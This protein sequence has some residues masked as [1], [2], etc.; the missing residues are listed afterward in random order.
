M[1]IFQQFDKTYNE[2]SNIIVPNN[3]NYCKLYNIT[4][5]EFNGGFDEFY[6]KIS[7]GNLR[8]YWTKI[9]LLKYIL[10]NYEDDWILMLDGDILLNNTNDISLLSKMMTEDKHVALC[11]ATNNIKDYWN[12]NIGSMLVRNSE[13]SRSILDKLINFGENTNF[14]TYEQPCLQYMIGSDLET[15]KYIEIFPPVVFNND[16]GPY[17]FHPVNPHETTTNTK[18]GKTVTMQNKINA[19]KQRISER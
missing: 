11:R 16:G 13:I 17:V 6:E 12:I 8:E 2:I 18:L 19:I 9:I 5:L 14:N 3:K 1:I 10:N 4:Y 15:S 7:T